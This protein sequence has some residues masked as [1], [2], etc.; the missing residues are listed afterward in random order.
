MELRRLL[1][2]TAAILPAVIMAVPA[3]AQ[4][5]TLD[6]PPVRL[7]LDEN[8]VVLS[9]GSIVTPSSSVSIGGANGLTHTRS[10]VGNGWRHN[11]MM[12][13]KVVNATATIALGG[14]SQ[15][16]TKVNGVWTSDQGNG[17]TLTETASLYTFKTSDGTVIEFDR[18]LTQS[19]QSYY[20][21]VSG[22]ATKI[23][24][25]SGQITTLNYQTDTYTYDAPDS[26]PGDTLF[27]FVIRLSS[28]TNN[29]G[30]QLKYTY[31]NNNPQ[32]NTVNDWYA[33]SKVTAINNADEY[34]DPMA[35]SCN[36]TGDWPFL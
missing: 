21:P 8:G 11:Y 2:G 10:R 24:A 33:I 7:P 23:T 28:V 5:Y 20:G 19:S 29:S 34:C 1:L 26:F 9:S 17:A 30:Y 3:A 32:S 6:P 12:T 25:P 27:I 35:N 15:T 22:L 31:A 36:L 16:F 14:G 4:S 13:V 18:G